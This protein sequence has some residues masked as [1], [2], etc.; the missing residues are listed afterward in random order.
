V[1]AV[2]RQFWPTLR[3]GWTEFLVYALVTSVLTGLLGF[4]VSLALGVVALGD[5]GSEFDL[6]PRQRADTRTR[7]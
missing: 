3:S 4:G 7:R 6:I 1:L 2:W 5:V